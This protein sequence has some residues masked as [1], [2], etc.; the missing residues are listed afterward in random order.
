[1]LGDAGDVEVDFEAA[2]DA[3]SKGRRRLWARA[4][5][6][7]VL[8]MP[9]VGADGAGVVVLGE[10]SRGDPDVD[11]TVEE[12]VVGSA[13]AGSPGDWNR[14]VAD[15]WPATTREDRVDYLVG[16]GDG[17]SGVVGVESREVAYEVL[18]VEAQLGREAF[19]EVVVEV[20][21]AREDEG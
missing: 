3:V 4:P 1:V 20:N 10:H 6:W 2:E 8:G 21:A 16:L 19:D 7:S 15:R 12:V 17:V 14:E 18:V 11:A 9:V 13:E 5:G